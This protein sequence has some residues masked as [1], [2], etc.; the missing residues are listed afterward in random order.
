MI[1]NSNI[2]GTILTKQ[3]QLT[4]TIHIKLR[5][6]STDVYANSPVR[7]IYTNALAKCKIAPCNKICK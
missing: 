2:N 3:I 7:F 5:S 6:P 4:E 1:M